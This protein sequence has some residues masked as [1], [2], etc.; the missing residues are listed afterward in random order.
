MLHSYQ[1]LNYLKQQQLESALVEVRRA[2]MVQQ[3]ALSVNQ[4]DI[5]AAKKKM[6]QQGISPESLS[7][8]YP[9]M[10]DS[11][12]K[13]KNSFQNAFT[14]YLSGLLYEAAGEKNDAYIDYKKALEIYPSNNYL[15]QD[16]LRLAHKLDMIDD[17]SRLTEQLP[18]LNTN[19]TTK[20]DGQLV[21]L[22]EQGIVASKQEFSL[23]LPIYTSHGDLRFYNVAL[24]IYPN[25][26]APTT[27]LS[28]TYQGEQYKSQEI[29][30]IQSLASKQLQDELPSI[31]TRQ[32]LRLLAKEHLRKKVTKEAG[33]IGNILANIYNIATEQADT[34][35]WSTLPDSIHILKL[36]LAAGEQQI[37]L[38]FAGRT[39]SITVKINSDRISLINVSAEDRNN[40]LHVINL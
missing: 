20:N 4:N 36:N 35:S 28:L 27:P 34:R 1:A 7:S 24:P 18:R 40:N 9:T 31:V 22:F 25:K 37:T 39:Q 17:I 29:V 12:G 10:T 8:K 19:K 14:F 15:Q 21:I 16:V 6:M 3:R 30:R 23:H 26:L 2:N 5:Y 38:N 32:V 13:I 33:D 11:I